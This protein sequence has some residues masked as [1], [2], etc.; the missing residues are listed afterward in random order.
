MTLRGLVSKLVLRNRSASY[1]PTFGQL[2]LPSMGKWCHVVGSEWGDR[3]HML[4]QALNFCNYK[5]YLPKRKRKASELV[6]GWLVSDGKWPLF[7]RFSTY[8]LT[9]PPSNLYL[10]EMGRRH[11]PLADMWPPA[12][13]L[14]LPLTQLTFPQ[15]RSCFF[16]NITSLQH[17]HSPPF[18]IKCIWVGELTK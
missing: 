11:S 4:P 15:S 3:V 17:C 13:I 18:L 6:R 5:H 16:F 8:W 14:H 9:P 12:R 7:D 2:M 1:G 10:A